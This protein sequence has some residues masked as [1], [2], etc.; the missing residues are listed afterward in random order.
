MTKDAL[1]ALVFFAHFVELYRK[2]SIKIDFI[3]E[4]NYNIY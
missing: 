1:F 4:L 2:N 3:F